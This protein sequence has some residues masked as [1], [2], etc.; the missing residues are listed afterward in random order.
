M[1]FTLKPD[2]VPHWF[3]FWGRIDV[4][5][6]RRRGRRHRARWPGR[7]GPPRLRLPDP[8]GR[9]RGI[10]SERAPYFPK[11]GR[12]D[13]AGFGGGTTLDKGALVYHTLVVGSPVSANPRAPAA[14]FRWVSGGPSILR[15]SHGRITLRMPTREPG[16]PGRGGLEILGASGARFRS[17]SASSL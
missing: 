5:R 6:P 2:T 9:A 14:G 7:Q 4:G 15:T 11:T 10:P 8:Q 12:L 16:A 13:T 1:P 17:W 3:G